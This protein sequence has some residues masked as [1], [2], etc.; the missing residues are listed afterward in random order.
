MTNNED[1]IKS[2]LSMGAQIAEEIRRR[3]DDAA[4]KVGV[5][6]S[7]ISEEEIEILVQRIIAEF[8][9]RIQTEVERAITRIGLARE[10]ELASLRA[11]IEKL[12]QQ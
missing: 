4:N 3:L 5:S 12:E 8:Q 2:F 6:D 11:R 9:D 7:A 1:A 10:D